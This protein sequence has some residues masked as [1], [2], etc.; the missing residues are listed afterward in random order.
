MHLATKVNSILFINKKAFLI[1]T[2]LTIE[3]KRALYTISYSVP[4]HMH[5]LFPA[6]FG[7]YNK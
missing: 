6:I 7:F 1:I 4:F 3:T 2:L 5:I